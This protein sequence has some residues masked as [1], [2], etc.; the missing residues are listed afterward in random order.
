MKEKFVRY[1]TQILEQGKLEGRLEGKLE[2][3][4]NLLALGVS[5]E[6]VA[7]AADLPLNKIKALLKTLKVEQPA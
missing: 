5:P 2:M 6:K 3:A 1:S 4:K 7:K